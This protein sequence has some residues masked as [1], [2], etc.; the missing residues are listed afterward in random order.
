[1]WKKREKKKTNPKTF[2]A[3]WNLGEQLWGLGAERQPVFLQQYLAIK[4]KIMLI[5]M[6]WASCYWQLSELLRHNATIRFILAGSSEESFLLW[7]TAPQ[8]QAG[9]DFRRK[10]QLGWGQGCTL[11]KT[12]AVQVW[13]AFLACFGFSQSALNRCGGPFSPGSTTNLWPFLP[14]GNLASWLSTGA[15]LCCASQE[16]KDEPPWNT[17]CSPQTSFLS[18]VDA[19]SLSF[20]VFRFCAA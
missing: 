19:F 1:M 6:V 4:T 11:L 9:T 5:V 17:L 10:I 15:R 3:S 20:R 18:Q 2:A 7:E 16:E 12:T 13:L 8:G 14:W